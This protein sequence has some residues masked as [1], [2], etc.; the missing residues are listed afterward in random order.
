MI[1]WGTIF[2]GLILYILTINDGIQKIG[3]NCLV[4]GIA[5]TI[6]IFIQPLIKSDI[7]AILAQPLTWAN[8]PLHL[9]LH[10]IAGPMDPIVPYV[11]F[12][13]YGIIFGI[14]YVEGLSKK[15]FLTYGYGLG[16]FYTILGFTMQTLTGGFT[17]NAY[18]TPPF[19]PLIAILGP[20][21]LATTFIVHIMDMRS[22]E[23][24]LKAIKRTIG[25]RTFGL[26]S[27]TAFLLEGSLSQIVHALINVFY[28]NSGANTIF[29]VLIFS[30]FMVILWLLILKLW[31][32][33]DFKGSFEWFILWIVSKITGK[34]SEKLNV[35]RLLRNP[36][37]Y[38]DIPEKNPEKEPI[39]PNNDSEEILFEEY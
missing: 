14:I 10:W 1:G 7:N 32:R 16:M 17:I 26:V 34:T 23:A 8:F 12:T 3:R 18:D 24:K 6:I 13:F 30:P 31:S 39:E 38:I 36:H 2:T 21:L 5:G 15:T 27:L 28:P 37:A 33:I 22:E 11:G 20:M 19:W 35:D 29:I 25:M 9:L 4:I